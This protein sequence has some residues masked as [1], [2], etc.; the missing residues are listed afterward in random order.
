MGFNTCPRQ[1]GLTMTVGIVCLAFL[2][3]YLE[4]YHLYSFKVYRPT[5][6]YQ[7]INM[8]FL[9]LSVQK[10]VGISIAVPPI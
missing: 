9:V 5:L 3:I 10:N 8:F 4:C 1:L 6:Y 7:C 2:Q